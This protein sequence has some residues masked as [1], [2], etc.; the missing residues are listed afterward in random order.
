MNDSTT[1]SAASNGR[2]APS[3][4]RR[5][6]LTGPSRPFD[7]T[8]QA[9]R[10]DLADVSEAEHHFAPH[11]AEAVT[12]VA[13]DNASVHAAPDAASAVVDQLKAGEGFALLDL[14]GSWAWGRTISHH[15]VGYV[16]AARLQP[17]AD[18]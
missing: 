2:E 6:R 8:T 12:W 7:P 11:Y 15:L 1:S 3:A 14:T 9:I 10:P 16:E 4:R 18:N 5:F 13:R 17:G